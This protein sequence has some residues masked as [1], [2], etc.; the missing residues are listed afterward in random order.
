[1][2][3]FVWQVMLGGLPHHHWELLEVRDHLILCESPPSPPSMMSSCRGC[4]DMAVSLVIHLWGSKIVQE[5]KQ[6]RQAQFPHSRDK[7]GGQLVTHGHSSPA[8]GRFL[9]P[10]EWNSLC[11]SPSV[12]PPHALCSMEGS[13]QSSGP[14]RWQALY[15]VPAARGAL[16]LAVVLILSPW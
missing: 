8:F 7:V 4:T 2:H 6:C 9:L 13:L 16:V 14:L 3:A 5:I 15:S 11:H 1:M 10:S 12:L